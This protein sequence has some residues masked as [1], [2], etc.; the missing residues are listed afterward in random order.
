MANV[1]GAV[2]N[3]LG[4][5]FDSRCGQNNDVVVAGLFTE[6]GKN[7]RARRQALEERVRLTRK[8]KLA[9]SAFMLLL[10]AAAV[11]VIVWFHAKSDATLWFLA[12]P[13]ALVL[14][15]LVRVYMAGQSL[16]AA[17]GELETSKM[18]PKDWLA[19]RT[20]YGAHVAG[21][22][23]TGIGRGGGGVMQGIAVGAGFELGAGL[24]DAF[25]RQ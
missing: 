20:K 1:R 15:M 10:V 25:I 9:N 4:L 16:R 19:Q 7:K 11:G 18:S 14:L 23:A 12:I 6:F 21:G 8:C 3:S 5:L 2:S 13:V 17:F 22:Q 24:V